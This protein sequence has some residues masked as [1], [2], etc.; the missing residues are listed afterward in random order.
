MKLATESQAKILEYLKMYAPVT[1]DDL[2]KR[3]KVAKT[4]VRRQLLNLERRGLV[5][6]EYLASGRG[7]PSLA[8]R[9]ASGAKEFF[10]NK[11]AEVL[12]E[13]LNYL[14]RSGNGKM[15][16]DFFDQY[17]EKRYEMILKRIREKGR[18]D[19]NTRLNALVEVLE[20]DGF[21]PTARLKKRDE[22]ILLRECHCP[23]EAVVKVSR[24]PC[25]LEQR[26]VARVLNAPISKVEMRSER[27]DSCDFQIDLPGQILSSRRR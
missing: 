7:R 1:V 15:L 24:L 27:K 25:R 21:M 23:I 2:T 3:M 17:W 26:L 20:A 14:I 16:D 9:L 4:A 11:E 22:Q 13:L 19:L 8:F 18:D 10:P 6:R 12:N 5:S